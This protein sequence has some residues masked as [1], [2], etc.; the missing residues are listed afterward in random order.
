MTPSS[1]SDH[2]PRLVSVASAFPKNV[3]TGSDTVSALTSLFPEEDRGFLE[4]LVLRSGVRERRIALPLEE[5]LAARTF[6]ERNSEW[7]EIALDLSRR[8]AAEAI[9][10]SGLQA[11]EIDDLIDVSCTGIAIPALDVDLAPALGLRADVRRVPITESGCAAGALAL[12]LGGDLARRGRRVLVVAVELCSLTLV[13][14]DVSRTNLVASVLFGDGAAAGILAPRG[15]GPAL[16][17]TG[18][19]LIADTR[20]MMG[21]DVGEHGLRIVLQR[22]LPAALAAHLRPA[23]LAFLARHGRGLEDVGL[24][25]VHPGGRRILDAYAEIFELPAG[26]LALSHES[27]SLHGNLSSAS[28]LTVLELALQRGIR[29]PK[30]RDALVLGVGPGLSLEFSLWS[31]D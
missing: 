8:A 25:L 23:V 12:S 22:E 31:W 14:G 18:S 9:A 29:P 6:G 5:T 2:A 28:I 24:H 21:F 30:G 11:S 7:S 16:L 10:R 27:L 3:V 4:E 26:A 17:A 20:S 1:P 13:R 19:H 15:Q